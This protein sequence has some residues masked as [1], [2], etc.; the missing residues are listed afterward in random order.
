MKASPR[1]HSVD[2]FVYAYKEEHPSEI[3]PSTKTLYNYNHQGLLA[4]KAI[5][6][7]KAV[8]LRKKT[9]K[10]SPLK[11]GQKPSMTALYLDIGKLTPY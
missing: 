11:R 1:V 10:R 7:P 9:K 6:L 4:I 3:V 2:S 8:R 5:D